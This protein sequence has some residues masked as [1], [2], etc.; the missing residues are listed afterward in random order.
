M[1][2]S[3][4]S[5]SD[6]QA[7]FC[8]LANYVLVDRASLAKVRATLWELVEQLVTL[9]RAAYNIEACE[10]WEEQLTE[11]QILDRVE[12]FHA[13]FWEELP[14]RSLGMLHHQAIDLGRELEVLSNFALSIERDK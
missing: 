12:Y 8:D 1:S 6:S 14:K 10:I 11:K 3:G 13:R 2:F 9:E 7:E 4:Q 5:D